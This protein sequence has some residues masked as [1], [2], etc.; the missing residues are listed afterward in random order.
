MIYRPIGR[1][2]VH[3]EQKPDA[4]SLRPWRTSCPQTIDHCVELLRPLGGNS[5]QINGHPWR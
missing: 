3:A 2:L 5:Q 1:R 4:S